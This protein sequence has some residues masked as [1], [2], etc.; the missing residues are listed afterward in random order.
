MRKIVI[1]IMMGLLLAA[2]VDARR[3]KDRAG[4]IKDG[5]YTDKKYN[6]QL[7]LNDGW[8]CKV[9]E[10][11]KNYRLTLTQKTFEI[12]PHYSDSKDYTKVPR[13][14][15]YV[16]TSSMGVSQFI[17]SL[18]SESFKSDQKKAVYKEFEILNK[19]SAGSGMTREDLVPRK[20]KPIDLADERGYLW[21]GKVKYRNEISATATSAGGKRVY[22][23]YFGCIIGVKKGNMIILFHTIC[24]ENY[25]EPM[26]GEAMTLAT[27]LK[28]TE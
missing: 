14:V 8:K 23:G 21:T 20:R 17:D 3:A 27:S 4:K 9:G 13:T 19:H 11:N 16:D 24:E 5:V 2:S 10:N 25:A 7:T 12:P 26:L 18:L 22:G 1:V 6:F 28:W 15:V